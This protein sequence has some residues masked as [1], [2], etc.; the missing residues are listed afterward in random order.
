VITTPDATTTT[1]TTNTESSGPTN[2]LKTRTNLQFCDLSFSIILV[3]FSGFLFFSVLRTSCNLFPA[4]LYFSISFE[5]TG[6]ELS[7]N[8]LSITEHSRAFLK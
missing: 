4:L 8:H 2:V 5:I 1:T 7:L 3:V 6:G